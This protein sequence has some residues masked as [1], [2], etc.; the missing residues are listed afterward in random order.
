M[1]SNGEPT[2]I[3]QMHAAVER[4]TPFVDAA[5]DPAGAEWKPSELLRI[6]FY[7][8]YSGARPE[9]AFVF[10]NDMLD[11]ARNRYAAGFYADPFMEPARV[12]P[13]QHGGKGA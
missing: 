1:A 10:I 6:G 9:S 11:E 13:H 12:R 2:A 3:E 4:A 8:A 7:A 5:H